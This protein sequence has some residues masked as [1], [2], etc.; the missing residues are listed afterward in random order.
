MS[1]IA[2]ELTDLQNNL[3][4]AKAAITSAGGTVGDTG[5]AG[6]ASEIATI[7]SGSGGGIDPLDSDYG[8]VYYYSEWN[9]RYNAMSDMDWSFAFSFDTDTFEHFFASHDVTFA[10]YADCTLF[11]TPVA[12]GYARMSYM[13][14]GTET[15]VNFDFNSLSEVE[16]ALGFT[17]PAGTSEN[18]WAYR[19]EMETV[20]DTTSNIV[21]G[22]LLSSTEYEELGKINP[23]YDTIGGETVLRGAIVSFYG[24]RLPTATP[25][26]FLQKANNLRRVVLSPNLTSIG[27]NFLYYCDVFNSPVTIP[28][29]VTSIGDAFLAGCT[30][31]NSRVG[32][33]GTLETI[34]DYFMFANDSFNQPVILPRGLTRIGSLESGAGAN[35]LTSLRAFTSY[36]DV[37]SLSPS[38]LTSGYADNTLCSAGQAFDT[39][40]TGITIKGAA[41]QDWLTAYPNT[42]GPYQW[43]KLL[44]GNA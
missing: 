20:A 6:L 3:A 25:Q 4:A 16:T 12:G 43:R 30:A 7:P 26:W 38:I 22:V 41:T 8:V 32:L 33:P 17:L 19:I 10:R 23:I 9:N 44:N 21:P 37:G 29:G 1:T 2:E 27:S 39:Y 36:V 34:G 18:S 42:D 40:T 31:F 5:L 28:E 11:T 14:W 24:G 35:F 15:N 13:D